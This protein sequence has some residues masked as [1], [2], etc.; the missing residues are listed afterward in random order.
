MSYYSDAYDSQAGS[1]NG[2]CRGIKRDG[3]RCS[4][5][6]GLDSRGYCWQHGGSTSS[7]NAR[8][9]SPSFAPPTPDRYSLP[10][11]AA[12]SDRCRGL[13]RENRPCSRSA[14]P[15]GFCYQ[16]LP[17]SNTQATARPYTSTYAA[18][19]PVVQPVTYYRPSPPPENGCCNGIKRDGYR[20][21]RQG[22]P[23][24]YCY[25]HLAQS[26]HRP[27]TAAAQPIYTYVASPSL[28]IAESSRCQ[29]I[30]RDGDRCTRS[31]GPTG[32]CYQHLINQSARVSNPSTNPRV[33]SGTGFGSSSTS[34]G[35]APS[36]PLTF[37]RRGAMD[38]VIELYSCN[39][40]AE[41]G[42]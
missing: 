18:P 23:S 41:S 11:Q 30:K 24:G 28:Q 13:T 33:P 31:A 8:Y 19:A 1:A 34:G 17:N 26:T 9:V 40:Q 25:Q 42:R 27:S 12:T 2:P 32:Y 10:P 7:S 21:T 37:G 20:C 4:R 14:G 36:R 3:D 35:A 39:R 38:K 29:G 16:H 5:G 22:G 6:N 15:S